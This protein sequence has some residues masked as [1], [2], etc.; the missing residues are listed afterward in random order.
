MVTLGRLGKD[1]PRGTGKGITKEGT[2]A[3]DNGVENEKME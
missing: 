3:K 1:P 2:W